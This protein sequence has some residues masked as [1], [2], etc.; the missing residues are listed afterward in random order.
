[1]YVDTVDS[2]YNQ[3]CS[4]KDTV[5]ECSMENS[6][7][8]QF[9]TGKTVFI[10]GA[11]GFMGKVL[12]E[13]LLRSTLVSKLYL[14]IRPKK[15][16]HTQQRLK[17]LLAGKIFDRIRKEN[18]EVLKKVEAIDGDITED[19]LGITEEQESLLEDTVN[20][21]FHCAATVRFDEDLTKSVAMNV[22]G[23]M[24]VIALAKKMTRLEALVDVST[25][26]CNCDLKHIEERIYPAP[27][28]PGGMVDMCQW[29][30]PEILNSPEVTRKMI[31][32][33]PNTYTFTKALAESV[34]SSS[35][36]SL[37]VSVMRPSIVSASLREPTPGWVDNFNGP[38][39][40]IAGAGKG[41]MRT[42]FCKR[43]CT[44]DMVP[45]DLCINLLCCVAWRTSTQT[46]GDIKVYNYTSGELNPVTWGEIEVWGLS[47]ILK[48]AYEGCMWYPGGSYK[49]N[50]YTNRLF[51]L[52][53][54]YGP[55]HCVDL[56][57]WATGKK[58]FLVRISDLMQKSAKA[59][60]TFTTNSWSWSN[61]NTLA[62]EADLTEEDRQMFG[63]DI[64]AVDWRSYLD[65]Y[66]QG[67][68]D[69][70]FQED[71]STQAACR[72]KLW[73]LY[74]LDWIVQAGFLLTLMWFFYCW[75]F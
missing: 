58:P 48:A 1:M 5:E 32:N 47:S 31:G 17:L 14:L 37:P 23:V 11:T 16:V 56:L 20:I 60:E 55:A 59:L 7:V 3:T 45:V 4:V 53:F 54:H 21:V 74:I 73:L 49:E 9:Y 71:P 26:Y 68:R 69:N 62:L 63:F 67:I 25:A 13:K 27:G 10:T 41:I 24:S 2:N 43:A 70:V 39:G 29:M 28:N 40:I 50:W 75:L 42:L 34:L 44:A 57:C 33:R 65:E 66:A 30:D 72:R 61:D 38:S 46:P 12:V 64:R 52:L 36:S 22:A 8:F 18:P 35:C 15:G 19:R 6:P 51:Q